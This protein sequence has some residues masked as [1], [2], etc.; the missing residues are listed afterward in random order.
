MAAPESD[1][2]TTPVDDS[3]GLDPVALLA[4][5]CGIA[6]IFVIQLV[7]V[8]LTLVLAAAAG[9]RARRGLGHLSWAYLAYG[10]G[11]VDGFLLIIGLLLHGSAPPRINQ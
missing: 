2:P 10:I 3:L 11:T 6:G 9:G 8:P 4:I 1:E 7:L 5:L